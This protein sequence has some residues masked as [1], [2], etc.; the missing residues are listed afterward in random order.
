MNG[1]Y[2]H[3]SSAVYV[4]VPTLNEKLVEASHMGIKGVSSLVNRLST[5]L[6]TNDDPPLIPM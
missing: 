1:P 6:L 4:L 5:K 3:V 2:A